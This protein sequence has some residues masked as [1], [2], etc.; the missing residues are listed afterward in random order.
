MY[1]GQSDVRVEDP[2][3]GSCSL[4]S[5]LEPICSSFAA[6]SVRTIHVLPAGC[7][8]CLIRFASTKPN[9]VVFFLVPIHW[10]LVLLFHVRL[11]LEGGKLAC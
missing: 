5:E 10:E 6:G 11:V 7:T 4:A 9:R 3:E 1:G 2:I 8:C